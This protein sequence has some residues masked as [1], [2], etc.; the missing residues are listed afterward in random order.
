MFL[1]C[2]ECSGKTQVIANVMRMFFEYIM[3]T[4]VKTFLV[5]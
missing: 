3:A 4:S 1:E 2:R 5:H